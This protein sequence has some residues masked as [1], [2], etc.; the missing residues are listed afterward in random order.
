MLFRSNNVNT[1]HCVDATVTDQNGA[2][3]AGA[4]VGFAV[5]GVNPRT[6]SGTTGQDGQAEFCY[7]GTV[8]GDDLITAT[9]GALTDTATKKWNPEPPRPVA[10]SLTPESATNNVNT[11]HCVDATVTD[12]NGAP[13]AGAA[14]DFAVTGANARTGAGTTGQNGQ[15]EFCY[16]GTVPGDDLI[17]ATSGAL[18]DTAAKTWNP[19]APAR[20]AALLVL[21]EETVQGKAFKAKGNGVRG[22]LP[23]FAE[24]VGGA[25]TVKTG[26]SGDEGW[27]APNC[28]PQKWIGGS[29]N[30]CLAGEARATAIDNFFGTNGPSASPSQSR[31]D[32]VPAVMPLRALGLTSLIGADVCAVVYDS[33]VSVNYNTSTF[34]FTDAN[35]QGK[36]L[37]VVAF[38]VDAVTWTKKS[39]STLPQVTL[40]ILDASVCGDWV[41]FNAPVPSSSSEPND[42]RADQPV[43]AIGGKGYRQL[44]A[45]PSE[46][47]FY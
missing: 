23:Y 28:I 47:L 5:T 26:Q 22:V 30:T 44:R 42:T 46:G 7:T 9:S 11:E 24:H 32:K 36:T 4:A 27:F 25:L 19:V 37:G 12:Q 45:R 21:D 2:P 1:E 13:F 38:R 20:G 3:F 16:T 17:R 18:T 31:L 39:S 35:L 14:V 41:L 43:T 34:P 10:L 29:S 8:V 40:T 33:D 15:A 6:G